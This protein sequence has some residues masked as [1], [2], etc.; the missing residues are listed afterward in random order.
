ML[1]EKHDEL[2]AAIDRLVLEHGATDREL[3]KKLI[4][5]RRRAVEARRKGSVGDYL[6]A[7]SSIAVV[8]KF[9]KD[10]MDDFGP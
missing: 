1:N 4:D 10:L 7:V 9:F 2:M 3:L 5:V 8:A 6:R